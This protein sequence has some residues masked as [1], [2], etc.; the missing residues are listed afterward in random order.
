[1]PPSHS[2]LGAPL[3][4]EDQLAHQRS[5]QATDACRAVL[6]LVVD[7]YA[8]GEMSFEDAVRWA[9]GAASVPDLILGQKLLGAAVQALVQASPEPK[10]SAGRRARPQLLNKLCHD[11]VELVR[12]REGLPITRESKRGPTAH[13]RVAEILTLR[14]I[15]HLTTTAVRKARGDWLKNPEMS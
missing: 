6:Q 8:A 5:E 7:S 15:K 14:G 9:S 1:M 13:E 11:L 4:P 12:D 2:L 10:G 3:K